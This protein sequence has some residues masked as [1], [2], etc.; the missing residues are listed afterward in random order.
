MVCGDRP[1]LR[2]L[3]AAMVRGIFGL[4]V[5]QQPAFDLQDRTINVVLDLIDPLALAV[6]IGNV[7]VSPHPSEQPWC[8]H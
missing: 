3:K 6:D 2:E 8:R 1:R 7:N 4:S 5:L